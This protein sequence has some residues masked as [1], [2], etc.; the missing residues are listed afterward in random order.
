MFSKTKNLSARLQQRIMNSV[1]WSAGSKY[2]TNP[3]SELAPEYL[4]LCTLGGTYDGKPTAEEVYA[5]LTT[6][7]TQVMSQEQRDMLIGAGET[8]ESIDASI[9]EREIASKEFRNYVASNKDTIITHLTKALS[10]KKPFV[11]VKSAFVENAVRDKIDSAL[12]KERKRAITAF[13]LQNDQSALH[14]LQQINA[15]LAS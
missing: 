1:V 13:S 2:A 9:K 15:V 14:E 7:D 12:A 3:H 8:Q 11:N 4:S 10:A 5:L 6:E